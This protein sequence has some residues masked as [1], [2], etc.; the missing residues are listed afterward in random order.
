MSKFQIANDVLY[1]LLNTNKCGVYYKQADANV[2]PRIVYHQIFNNRYSASNEEYI[3]SFTFQVSLFMQTMDFELLSD[4]MGSLKSDVVFINSDW[5][6]GATESKEIYH[7][8]LE[9]EV[10][11]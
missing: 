5:L 11:V 9:V 2:Y 10:L 7:M 8:K 1:S 3:T 4:V 6:E